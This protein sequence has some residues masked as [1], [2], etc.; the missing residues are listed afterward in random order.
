[1]RARIA[2]GL[3]LAAVAVGCTHQG[4]QPKAASTMG[5]CCM[6]PAESNAAF[7]SIKKLQGT[8]VTVDPMKPGDKPWTTIFKTTSGGSA[9]METLAAGSEH[10]MVNLYT[11]G[12]AGVVMTHYCHMGNQPRMKLTGV[13]D[14]AMSFAFV[15]GGNIPNRNAPHMDSMTLTPSADKLSET[16][17]FYADGKATE[18]VT[19]NFKKQG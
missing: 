10:E 7:D 1:M 12:D 9:V 8:W 18:T 17:T 11:T 2:T 13:K 6:A 19:F 5:E 3:L 15:D 14:G 4:N 16:W